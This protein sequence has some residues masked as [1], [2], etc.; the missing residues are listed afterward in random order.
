V[1][2]NKN[3]LHDEMEE[4]AKEERKRQIGEKRMQILF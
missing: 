1:A 4:G 2:V 3:C